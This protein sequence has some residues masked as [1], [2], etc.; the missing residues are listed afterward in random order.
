LNMA[1]YFLAINARIAQIIKHVMNMI[2]KIWVSIAILGFSSTYAASK[3]R[4]VRDL[5]VKKFNVRTPHWLFLDN[6]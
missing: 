2:A 4:A 5:K 3:I 6:N 1:N